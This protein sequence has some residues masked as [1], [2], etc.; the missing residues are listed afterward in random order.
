MLHLCIHCTEEGNVTV[1]FFSIRIYEKILIGERLGAYL[2]LPTHECNS[3]QE[4]NFSKSVDK[5]QTRTQL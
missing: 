3:H 2:F 1:R 4:N 5:I